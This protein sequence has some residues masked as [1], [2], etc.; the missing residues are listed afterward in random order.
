MSSE[1]FP[2]NR[3]SNF[4]VHLPQVLH[5]KDGKYEAS[6]MDF[7]ID[8]A[9]PDCRIKLFN[10][11]GKVMEIVCL[12]LNGTRDVEELLSEINKR[13]ASAINDKISFKY[14][15]SKNRVAV[16]VQDRYGIEIPPSLSEV[17]GF[18]S[19]TIL[20]GKSIAP[21][22]PN[23]SLIS[24]VVKDTIS[25][26]CDI[27]EPQIFGS[28]YQKFLRTFF[29]QDKRLSRREFFYSQPSFVPVTQE[30]F[31][32]INIRICNSEGE[33]LYCPEGVALVT[34]QFKKL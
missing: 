29:I 9:N 21:E 17:L 30:R 12:S 34:L 13:I 25:I 10:N 26:Y 19:T 3:P 6:L 11:E 2:D 32:T 15:S 24:S 20:T 5:F 7:G 14:Y 18:G 23:V 31:N 28:S 1:Y 33:E 16:H 4:R 22:E 27:I 8:L